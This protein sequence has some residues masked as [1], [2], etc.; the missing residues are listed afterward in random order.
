[1]FSFLL[2]CFL[3]APVS[4]FCL[5]LLLLAVLLMFFLSVFLLFFVR[6]ADLVL[7]FPLIPVLPHD[8]T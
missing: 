3:L 2:F 1:M 6:F 7:L 4:V 5:V 8:Y